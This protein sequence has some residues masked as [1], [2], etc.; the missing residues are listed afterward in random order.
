MFL[1]PQIDEADLIVDRMEGAWKAGE[2]HFEFFAIA[3]ILPVGKIGCRI[4]E[5]VV[6]M[7]CI[8]E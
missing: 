8:A 1:D 2:I 3:L 7:F 4:R 5:E 6:H